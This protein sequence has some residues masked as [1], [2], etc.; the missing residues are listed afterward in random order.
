MAHVCTPA[1]RAL[2]QGESG[3][4]GRAVSDKGVYVSPKPHRVCFDDGVLVLTPASIE[5]YHGYLAQSLLFS[6]GGGEQEAGLRTK[7][8]KARLLIP[9]CPRPDFDGYY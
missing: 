2:L 6:G 7:A 5:A 4:A 3:A 9:I 8:G 1:T